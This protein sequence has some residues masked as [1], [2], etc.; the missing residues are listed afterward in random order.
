MNYTLQAPWAFY[1]FVIAKTVKK[2]TYHRTY[3]DPDGQD[4]TMLLYNSTTRGSAT[5]HA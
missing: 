3:T 4:Y 5:Q 2:K 1:G